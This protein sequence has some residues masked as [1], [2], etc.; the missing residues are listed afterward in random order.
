MQQSEHNG[1]D[2]NGKPSVPTALQQPHHIPAKEHFFQNARF[3]AYGQR[4]GCSQ[5]GLSERNR[6]YSR[7]AD[8]QI[9]RDHKQRQENCQQNPPLLDRTG[10]T[11]VFHA[12]T[13]P[14]RGIEPKQ[15]ICKQQ[16]AAHSQDRVKRSDRKLHCGK[17][18]VKKQAAQQIACQK[19][20]KVN[21][22]VFQC[23]CL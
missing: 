1:R 21:E 2:Q 13:K 23:V 3:C 7:I 5:K 16:T 15:Q 9:G 11:K 18:Q 14:L 10:N 8:E 19:Q 6:I 12:H 4:R 22:D 20:Q 17:Q